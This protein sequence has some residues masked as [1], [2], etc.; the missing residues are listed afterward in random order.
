MNFKMNERRP[1]KAVQ[2]KGE[3]ALILEIDGF[4]F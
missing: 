4:Y 3:G 1:L 2:V